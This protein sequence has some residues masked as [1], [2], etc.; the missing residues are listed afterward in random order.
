MYLRVC[1]GPSFFCS[2]LWYYV[3][4]I[5]NL[6]MTAVFLKDAMLTNKGSSQL[7]NFI[8]P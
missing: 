7:A 2:Y 5:I 1:K 8:F 3:T 6:I 4:N